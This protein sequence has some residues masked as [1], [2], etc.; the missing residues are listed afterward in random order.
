MTSI[1]VALSLAAA[2]LSAAV[3]VAEP[4]ARVRAS[5]ATKGDIWVG[6]RVT[7][8]VELLT[9]GF[10]ASTAAFDLPQVSGVILIPPEDR[11]VV[12]SETVDGTTFTT[13]R[14]ELAVFA[15]R[16]GQVEIPGFVVRFESSPALGKPT[17][18]QRVTTPAVAFTA[19]LPPGAAGLSTVI[20]TPEL[21]V[22]E[23]WEPEPGKGTAKLGAAFTR[24][25][26]VE[27]RDVPGMVLPAFRFDP[28]DGL[29]VYPKPPV[30]EDR[31]ERGELFGRR[32]ETVTYVCEKAG[33]FSLPALVWAW[34]DPSERQLK[35][36]ELPATTFDVT[37]PQQPPASAVQPAHD[38]GPTW[39]WVV[40][41][42]AGFL[43]VG[44]AAWRFGPTAWAGW[45]RHREA[46]A[47]SESAYFTTF[48]RACRTGDAHATQ[49]ALLAWLDRFLTGDTAPSTEN[50]AARA[51]DPEL[52]AE[53]T[54]LEDVVYGRAGPRSRQ[55]LAGELLRRVRA[56][57]SRLRRKTTPEDAGWGALPPLNPGE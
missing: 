10:F 18:A 9:P 39:A 22:K 17:V 47:A 23:A 42:L 46:A 32:V 34:W 3:V 19:K 14:H 2:G 38:P 56:A 27:A 15:Q 44:V 21:T 26:T 57:R 16:A 4:P 33:A 1:R 41:A 54:A 6:Q 13:Q 53:L 37:A 28:P 55:W 40:G 29:G 25:I 36:V 20:T 43:A 31:T 7:L 5:I 48:E 51:A 45:K 49:R 12:G 30:V 50:L 24:T 52:T 35:R 11:P 8:V